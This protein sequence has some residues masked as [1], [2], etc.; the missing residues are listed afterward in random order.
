MA[1]SGSRAAREKLVDSQAPLV[2]RLDRR[3]LLRSTAIKIPVHDF[4]ERR[5]Q[6]ERNRN[7]HP[8][9]GYGRSRMARSVAPFAGNWASHR[10]NS[11]DASAKPEAGLLNPQRRA[12][13]N[14]LPPDRVKCVRDRIDART[15]IE[16]MDVGLERE[17]GRSVTETPLDSSNITCLR[18]H[19]RAVCVT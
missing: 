3:S 8:P 19:D 1:R 9:E 12:L 2:R 16:E 4:A 15:I 13:T 10:T 6:R 11:L 7:V 5:V 18:G 14:W 17:G